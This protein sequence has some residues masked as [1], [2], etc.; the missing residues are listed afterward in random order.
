LRGFNQ[1]PGGEVAELLE[2]L[3]DALDGLQRAG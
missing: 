2:L 3:Q 1:L